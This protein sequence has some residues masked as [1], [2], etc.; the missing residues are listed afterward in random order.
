MTDN[1]AA[2]EAAERLTFVPVSLDEANTFVKQHHRRMHPEDDA[3]AL[4]VYHIIDE[5]PDND[6]SDWSSAH[7]SGR[8]KE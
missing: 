7:L 6:P 2:F 3:T 5:H 8:N 4:I 1:R